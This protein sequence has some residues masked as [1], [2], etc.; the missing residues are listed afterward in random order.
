MNI[1]DL[2]EFL[3]SNIFKSKVTNLVKG[4]FRDVM[5][6]TAPFTIIILALVIW[7]FNAQDK[8]IKALENSVD[9]LN[10]SVMILEHTIEL[11]TKTINKNND[12]N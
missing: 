11:W 12:K 9:G 6:L 3:E 7:I 2:E 1:K 10:R 4:V 8:N 5:K